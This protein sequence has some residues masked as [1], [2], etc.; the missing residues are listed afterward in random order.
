MSRV[1]KEL[2][3]ELIAF[4]KNLKIWGS[5]W[6]PH[7]KSAF[8]FGRQMSSRKL[9]KINAQFECN[10]IPV[11]KNEPARLVAEYL[12]GSKWTT[13]TAGKS[14]NDLR[15]EFFLRAGDAEDNLDGPA[16]DAK[17]GADKGKGGK[18]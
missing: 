17:K 13:K 5:F 11:E 9:K 12:D 1:P 18:K 4:A 16:T 3:W 8:E 10:F 14:L 6:D 15:E 2:A 7:A